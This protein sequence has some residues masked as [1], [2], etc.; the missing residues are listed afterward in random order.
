M[1]NK[2]NKDMGGTTIIAQALKKLELFFI[3]SSLL[4]YIPQRTSTG[5]ALFTP[6]QQ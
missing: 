1:E 6:K 2:G 3:S 4:L 5:E